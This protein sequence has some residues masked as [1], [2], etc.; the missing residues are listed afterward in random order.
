MMYY[1]WRSKGI[2]PS[3]FYR[4]PKGELLVVQAFYEKELEDNKEL[5][6]KA[7]GKVLFTTNIEV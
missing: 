1:Y 2:F 7:D 3:V 5:I 4:L 6:R